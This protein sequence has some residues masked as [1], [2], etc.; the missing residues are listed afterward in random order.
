ME[1]VDKEEEENWQNIRHDH[2]DCH[3]SNRY[4]T[5]PAMNDIL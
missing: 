1:E 5:N 2:T 4:H 3:T